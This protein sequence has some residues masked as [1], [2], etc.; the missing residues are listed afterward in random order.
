[1]PSLAAELATLLGPVD[2]PGDY[3][4][5]GSVELLPPSLEI[6][7]I[8]PIALP[9]L[10]VQA[11]RII[12]LA[13]A[14]PFGRGEETIVDP[15]VRR[16]WQIGPDRVRLGGRHWPRTLD[17]ILARVV[18][19]LGVVGPVRA[20]FYKLLLYERGGFFVDHRDTEKAPGMFATLVV[21]L[22]SH[23]AGGEL[24]VRH[25][26]RQ[27]C[28]GLRGDDPA[29]ASF[30][31]FY[32]DCRH[33][34]MPVAEGY[35]LTLVYN[36]IRPGR[37][38]PPEPP[39]F[40]KEKARLAALLQAWG[41]G[42]GRFDDVTPEKLVYP[43]EHAYTPAE[44][45]FST[46]KGRDAAAAG[47]LCSAAQEAGCDLHL[48]LLTIEESGAAEYAESYGRSR[49]G[50]WEAGDEE[51]EAGEVSDRKVTLSD[52]RCRDGETPGI[53]EIPVEEG[54]L[55]PPDACDDL[56]P[57]EETFHE[58]TGNEGASF[59]RSYRRAALVLWPHA[60]FFAVLSQ[61]GL[62][63]TLPYLEDLARRAAESAGETA[64]SLRYAA[65]DLATRMMARWPGRSQSP[66]DNTVPS[67]VARM[68][69][70]LAQL[71]D[72]VC[73]ERFVTEVIAAGNFARKDTTALLRALAPLP[74]SQRAMLVERVIAG[75]GATAFGACADLLARATVLWSADSTATLAGAAAR[76]VDTMPD[77]PA[78][79]EQSWPK[80]DS[81][82]VSSGIV[83]DLLT[84]LGRF[85]AP[86]AERAVET[87]LARPGI[88]EMDRVLLPAMRTLVTG[89]LERVRGFEQ[90]R[91]ACLTHL[92][93]RT[94]E[95]LAPP[96]DWRRA[97]ALP[98]HCRRCTEL[99]Q[100]LK[101]PER[102]SW[103]LKAAEADRT[104]VE[105]TIRQA[106]CDLDMATDRRG[107]PY[108]LVCTKNQASYDRRAGQ[109]VQ[110]L[111]DLARLTPADGDAGTSGAASPG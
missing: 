99:A 48:A 40:T 80:D 26:G 9:L 59:E 73:I 76:L 3:V 105:G 96:A 11:D 16:C 100:F 75:T 4:T 15:A 8:G 47:V 103:S 52:W 79:G 7:G 2:R 6:E 107:R 69:E 5:S 25:K 87:M 30:A 24:V 57:D 51:F 77:G 101:D 56:V 55:S 27:A 50:R 90:L 67:A 18:V 108:T 39:D 65:R 71:Q 37:G 60:R 58:A 64:S 83:I 78:R 34:L 23:F 94:A 45:G 110:D 63:A 81:A 104:H 68:L 53:G 42:E 82:P 31:A 43:L 28:L 10:P 66:W 93:A 49:R 33:E 92:R 20:E 38:R 32:A 29:E 74:P 72:G 89:G 14:A 12:S 109:R 97:S 19:G 13:E 95:P 54:E 61:A 21:V 98:C 102:Q 17:A 88:Y 86:L 70:A 84:G 85:H 46:L 35:R 44:L 111:G 106:R 22:P 91:A 41:T 1:M 36:L 62:R